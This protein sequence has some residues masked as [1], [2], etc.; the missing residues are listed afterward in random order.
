[1]SRRRGQHARRKGHVFFSPVTGK[2]IAGEGKVRRGRPAIAST[3]GPFG[4]ATWMDLDGT[5]AMRIR[6]H[7]TM[8]L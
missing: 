5:H 8:L 1:M 2:T 4:A 6:I 7:I 3:A